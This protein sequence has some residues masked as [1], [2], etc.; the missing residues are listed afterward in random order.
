MLKTTA[1]PAEYAAPGMLKRL[2]AR[3]TT[4]AAQFAG[5][6]SEFFLLPARPPGLR[7]L[8]NMPR[9]PVIL[10][11]LHTSRASRRAFST[12][13]SVVRGTH[14]KDYSISGFILGSPCLG[15]LPYVGL[16]GKS[17]KL[18]SCTRITRCGPQSS[19][20][21][22]AI[23]LSACIVRLFLMQASAGAIFLSL[24]RNA[25]GPCM[26]GSVLVSRLFSL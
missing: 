26:G 10:T 15:K 2:R 17:K 24:K 16:T 13:C 5:F 12:R 25:S 4:A 3:E 8:Q 23:A 19:Q 21:S 9:L 6:F 22:C 14:K 20:A 1:R 18:S 11:L 7:A